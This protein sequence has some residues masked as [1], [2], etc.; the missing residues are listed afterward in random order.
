MKTT[1]KP[2]RG[3]VLLVVLGM[4]G[5]FS[6]LAVTYMVYSGQSRTSGLIINR[7]KLQNPGRVQFSADIIPLI[8]R[9]SR[10]DTSVFTMHSLLGD[11]YGREAIEGYLRNYSTTNPTGYTASL[12]T[13]TW[14]N[15]PHG[16]VIVGAQATPTTPLPSDT[17]FCKL[18]LNNSVV[19]SNSS[20]TQLSIVDD[21]Y[22]ARV[23]TMLE[24]PLANQSFRILKYIGY[25]GG[26]PENLA[27]SILIDLAECPFDVQLQG[28]VSGMG[29][30]TGTLR[31]WLASYSVNSLFYNEVGNPY[32]FLINDAV[33]NGVGYGLHPGVDGSTDPID[34]GGNLTQYWTDTFANRGSSSLPRPNGQVVP[35]GL[36]PNM[37]YIKPA[38]VYG[39]TNEGIDVPDFRDFWLACLDPNGDFLDHTGSQPGLDRREI[40]PSYHRPELVNYL[41]QLYESGPGL[42]MRSQNEIRDLLRMVD[43]ACARPLAVSLNGAAVITGRPTNSG[44]NVGSQ[45]HA[46]IVVTLLTSHG[47]QQ[48]QFHQAHKT[49]SEASFLRLFKVLG[50]GQRW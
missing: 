15:A 48:H 38:N 8:L 45:N 13:N 16:A 32:R 22:N 10:S 5:L 25:E 27:Y 35:V 37:D 36:L 2:H 4:L 44:F 21:A 39:S 26:T 17:T 6:L 9:G 11:I 40:I 23:F 19:F 31:E 12:T 14:N 30:A 7:A 47:P 34:A 43:F 28:Q 18:S 41:W 50:R 20:A 42:G 24:G 46:G 33:Y 29:T 49:S 3:L 1:P